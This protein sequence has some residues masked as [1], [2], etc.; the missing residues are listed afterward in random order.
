MKSGNKVYKVYCKIN[1]VNEAR[2]VGLI[3]LL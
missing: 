2:S 1:T 3:I